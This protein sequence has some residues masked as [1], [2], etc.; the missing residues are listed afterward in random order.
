MSRF[1][2][3]FTDF[4]TNA[5]VTFAA[6]AFGALIGNVTEGLPR[7]TIVVVLAVGVVATAVALLRQ[8]SLRNRRPVQRVVSRQ[9]RA[10]CDHWYTVNRDELGQHA[11][12][13]QHAALL[14]WN[15]KNP[16]WDDIVEWVRKG[17]PDPISRISTLDALV[18][19][20][21]HPED[22]AARLVVEGMFL[23]VT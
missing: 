4:P 23:R 14:K 12:V 19:D 22:T 2:Q 16:H 9:E 10:F 18:W 3:Y 11:A 1:S 21:P 8:F 20:D 17:A 13:V 7:W 5:A 6:A 15:A